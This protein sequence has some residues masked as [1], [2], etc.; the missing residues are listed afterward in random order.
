M[1]LILLLLIGNE[2]MEALSRIHKAD[3]YYVSFGSYFGGGLITVEQV[4]YPELWMRLGLL[5]RHCV[6]GCCD[7]TRHHPAAADTVGCSDPNLG[8]MVRGGAQLPSQPAWLNLV[9][10]EGANKE[11]PR[12]NSRLLA[13]IMAG[14][15]PQ[16]EW[17]E[18][19]AFI[20]LKDDNNDTQ[21]GINN[22]VDHRYQQQRSPKCKSILRLGEELTEL[23]D[24]DLG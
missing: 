19:E 11:S 15:D 18:D 6:C 5:M 13:M 20:K 8:G 7:T 12:C 16:L 9:G 24:V 23:P 21:L 14:V 10:A 22:N 2:V 3:K 17:V 4:A 1:V